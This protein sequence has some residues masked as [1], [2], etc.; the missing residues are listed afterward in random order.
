MNRKKKKSKKRMN[1][2]INFNSLIVKDIK[3]INTLKSWIVPKGKKIKAELLYR[4]SKDGESIATFHQLCDNKGPTITLFE[5]LNGTA[6]GF[7]SPL[8]FDSNYGNFKQ[9]MNTFIFNLDNQIKF[10]KI[11]N[12]GSIYCK[13]T[14]GP[15]V[16]YFG[17]YDGEVKNMKKCYYNPNCTKNKFKNGNNII[18]NNNQNVTFDLKEVEIWKINI[19]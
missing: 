13:N 7:Y 6:I 11:E 9:D 12:D 5:T 1:P 14:F 8:D 3:K 17:M 19:E 15:Y 16:A 4:L 18:P 2:I 10:G